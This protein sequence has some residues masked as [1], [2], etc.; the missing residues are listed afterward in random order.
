MKAIS[1]LG[2]EPVHRGRSPEADDNGLA[3]AEI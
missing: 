3:A 1:L 2:I